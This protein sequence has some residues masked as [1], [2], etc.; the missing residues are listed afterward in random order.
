MESRASAPLHLEGNERGQFY[1]ANLVIFLASHES[2]SA[3]MCFSHM[4][5]VHELYT[6]VCP[7]S[8]L[9]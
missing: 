2:S 5:F 3:K 4:D 7:L 9:E 6:N 1:L 8:V